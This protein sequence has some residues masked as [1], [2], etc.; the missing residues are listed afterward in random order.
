MRRAATVV[1]SIVLLIAGG[2]WLFPSVPDVYGMEY[3]PAVGVLQNAGFQAREATRD[4]EYRGPIPIDCPP[5]GP[6]VFSSVGG[7]ARVA[8]QNANVGA[9]GHAL[10]GST[11]TLRTCFMEGPV[12]IGVGF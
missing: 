2:W 6:G 7:S 4:D 1:A 11:I 9:L 3:D 5:F 8:Y 10:R 12:D